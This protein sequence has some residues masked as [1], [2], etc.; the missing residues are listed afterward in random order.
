MDYPA[1][2]VGIRADSTLDFSNAYATGVGEWDV[3]QV[4]YAYTQFAPGADER[5]GLEAILRENR[6]QRLRV[7]MSDDDTRPAGAAH[8]LA[9]MWDNGADPV[10]E[11][12][13]E[14]AVRRIALARLR[15]AQRLARNAAG[16]AR[17]GAGAALLPSPLRAGGRRQVGRRAR[18]RLRG[19]RRRRA[20][21][22]TGAG[23]PPARGH[24]RRCSARW[25][26]RCSTCPS[27]CSDCCRRRRSTT[28]R[29]A[30]SSARTPAPLSTRWAPQPPLRTSRCPYCCRPSDSRAWSISTAAT[31]TCR[32]STKCSMR[33][34]AACSPRQLRA[35]RAGARSRVPSKQPPC[36]D[37]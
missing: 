28:R 4:R 37:S 2:L 12:A 24:W 35:M 18:L 36:A 17:R 27:R 30:S 10:A 9:A 26:P 3:Q 8:P 14:L 34:R 19:A 11:L 31:T 21:R 32:A 22:A 1:P 16:D 6:D 29:I 23:S 13:H 20:A 7:Y 33:S 15:R 25:I 5:A